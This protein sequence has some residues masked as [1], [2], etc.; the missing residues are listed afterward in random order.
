VSWEG[1][2]S[3]ERSLQ[4]RH[5][6]YG[7]TVKNTASEPPAFHT[8]LIHL[9]AAVGI[10]AAVL[11]FS[12]LGDRVLTP[13]EARNA[14]P[15]W[16]SA[17][18]WDGELAD[19]HF[20]HSSPL[21]NNL[22]WLTFWT[23]GSSDALARCGPAL[24][25]SLV[26][27][28]PWFLR[29]WIGSAGAFAG[30]VLLALDPWQLAFSRSSDSAILSVFFALA[31]LA[32]VEGIVQA[33][34]RVQTLG[35]PDQTTPAVLAAVLALFAAS[36]PDFWSL[37]VPVAIYA[38]LVRGDSLFAPGCL[39]S[40]IPFGSRRGF[41]GIFAA[42]LFLS[43]F[44]FGSA[45]VDIAGIGRGLTEW[46]QKWGTATASG[47]NWDW[48]LERFLKDDP[49]T[50][51]AGLA[52]FVGLWREGS[53]EADGSRGRAL[54]L[55]LWA[56][57]GLVLTVPGGRGPAGLLVMDLPLLLAAAWLLGRLIVLATRRW[58]SRAWMWRAGPVA[59][60][61]AATCIWTRPHRQALFSS[62]LARWSI[63][64]FAAAAAVALLCLKRA[65]FKQEL[66]FASMAV[67][68][69]A[70]LKGS[71]EL[72]R[73]MGDQTAFFREIGHPEARLLGRDLRHWIT[74][75][76]WTGKG[77][78]VRIASDVS[79]AFLVDWHL[80]HLYETG[81]MSGHE[82]NVERTILITGADAA[83][84]PPAE[85]SAPVPY[86]V[87]RR[88]P[89]RSGTRSPDSAPGQA[90]PTRKE[91]EVVLLWLPRM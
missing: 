18:G 51:A 7:M 74:H 72:R 42:V 30:M 27:V 85:S 53:R 40:S 60:F 90:S 43:S 71:W 73:N 39:C 83:L 13:D 62:G 52:G 84:Q 63:C 19:A 49:L 4:K 8:T 29:R 10:F 11:R 65:R 15:A 16:V 48:V 44:A 50:V 38:F 81:L 61:L 88:W 47:Y 59:A 77:L 34:R 46:L 2:P 1:R 68:L 55:S 20:R 70:E 89:S 12:A 6:S 36:G 80:R 37:A 9:S 82:S 41:A 57:W 56:V 69:A 45:R 25:G 67:L 3:G 91:D 14:W 75:S 21:L 76:G 31:A 26:V 35:P 17:G 54:A 66:V 32:C 23:L 64:L 58:D 33:N 78:S 28:L 5:D 86:R 22:T 79:S 24:F 87:I